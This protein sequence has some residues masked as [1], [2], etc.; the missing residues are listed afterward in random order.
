MD[1]HHLESARTKVAGNPVLQKLIKDY[2]NSV[3]DVL[4]AK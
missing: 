3:W 1:Q 4:H 2:A